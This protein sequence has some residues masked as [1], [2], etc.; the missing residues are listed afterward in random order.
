MNRKTLMLWVGIYPSFFVKVPK[1]TAIKIFIY[2][3]GYCDKHPKTVCI[4]VKEASRNR[5]QHCGWKETSLPFYFFFSFVG[6]PKSS[7]KWVFFSGWSGYLHTHIC[8]CEYE[9]AWIAVRVTKLNDNCIFYFCFSITALKSLWTVF[10]CRAWTT[11]RRLPDVNQ[12]S[13]F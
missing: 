3:G 5:H 7:F 1:A 9:R 11:H 12:Y 8:L 2:Q 13:I 4:G 6:V 10:T